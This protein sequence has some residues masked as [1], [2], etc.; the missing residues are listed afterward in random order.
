MVLDGLV[1]GPERATM[2]SRNDSLELGMIPSIPS[3][4]S[5]SPDTVSSAS[6][7]SIRGCYCCCFLYRMSLASKSFR[8]TGWLI[9][10]IEF[11][12]CHSTRI[13][14]GINLG[15]LL[16]FESS[17]GYSGVWSRG[18]NKI[19]EMLDYSLINNIVLTGQ[20]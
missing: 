15:R 20:F 19:F 7:L 5:R 18:Y 17:V 16:L 4:W 10:R 9:D 3:D 12:F 8:K 13:D 2:R 6:D 1:G 14:I 11:W